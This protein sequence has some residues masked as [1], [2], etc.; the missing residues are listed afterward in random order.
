MGWAWAEQKTVILWTT[1]TNVD[2][3]GEVLIS[4]NGNVGT[5]F[6]AIVP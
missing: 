1:W 5:L 3:F 6:W 2:F 4:S